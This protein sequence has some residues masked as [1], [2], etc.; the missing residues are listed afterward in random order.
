MPAWRELVSAFTRAGRVSRAAACLDA[1]E[2][3]D[4]AAVGPDATA[5]RRAAGRQA[6]ARRTALLRALGAAE[7]GR[8]SVL[9]I[10]S[11]G[12]EDTRRTLASLADQTTDSDPCEVIV[13]PDRSEGLE[14]ATGRY[15]ACIEA[16]DELWP[17]HLSLLADHL[18]RTGRAMTFSRALRPGTPH[19]FLTEGSPVLPR[20]AATHEFAPASC[21]LV[22]RRDLQRT[23][24]FDPALG[25]GQSW[26]LLRRFVEALSADAVPVPS[27][28]VAAD[29]LS[30]ERRFDLLLVKRG[31]LARARR[32]H[33]KARRHLSRGDVRLA[34]QDLGRAWNL[35][36]EVEPYLTGI[37]GVA[38][39][40]RGLAGNLVALGGAEVAP[41]LRGAF[42][43]IA[44]GAEARRLLALRMHRHAL[45]T[46]YGEAEGRGLD[47]ARRCGF[48][49]SPPA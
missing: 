32:W 5:L 35:G 1:L 45:R 27:V 30:T 38:A 24:G 31:T 7:T 36:L 8:V 44:R 4:P 49:D 47:R 43:K 33:R 20:Q 23:G 22:R 21:V 10:G 16:G 41:H 9:V 34:A 2:A 13:C 15:L 29:D 17:D 3:A 19:P 18:D 25:R 6:V 26:H 12:A 39:H 46:R 14:R 11:A 40:S 42:H 48:E 28:R 37:A